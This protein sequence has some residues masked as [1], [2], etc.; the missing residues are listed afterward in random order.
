MI[1]TEICNRCD[2]LCQPLFCFWKST[3]GTVQ[4]DHRDNA[5][6]SQQ[7]DLGLNPESQL[8]VLL[9]YVS[10]HPYSEG[11]PLVLSCFYFVP[12]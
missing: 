5:G 7:C 11:F 12:L 10:L 8:Y 2:F 6:D 4:C 3:D 9:R 1:E